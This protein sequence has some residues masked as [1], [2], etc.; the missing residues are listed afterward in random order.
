[1]KTSFGD[2]WRLVPVISQP[3][4]TK[5]ST[6]ASDRMSGHG[7][8]SDVVKLDLPPPGSPELGSL[9]AAQVPPWLLLASFLYVN[10]HVIQVWS[11]L[12]VMP[13]LWQQA[14]VR[15]KG[16][17]CEGCSSTPDTPSVPTGFPHKEEQCPYSLS[18]KPSEKHFVED[19]PARR[20]KHM[21]ISA[22]RFHFKQLHLSSLDFSFFPICETKYKTHD[23]SR[24]VLTLIF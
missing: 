18:Q 9:G 5:S 22:P 15:R 7:Q 2:F 13:C 17:G 10:C 11:L 16:Q 20:A 21:V 23:T 4:L 12:T 3:A 8:L 19:R 14:A 24:P 6:S 1:M